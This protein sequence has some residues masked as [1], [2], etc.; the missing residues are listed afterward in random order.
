[1]SA[2]PSNSIHAMAIFE[3]RFQRPGAE[4]HKRTGYHSAVEHGHGR[5]LDLEKDDMFVLIFTLVSL[6]LSLD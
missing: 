3:V 2:Q 1:M 5:M 4:Q 6:G